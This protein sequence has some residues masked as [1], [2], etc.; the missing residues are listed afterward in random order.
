[1]ELSVS[2]LTNLDGVGLRVLEQVQVALVLMLGRVRKL[3][4][5]LVLDAESGAGTGVGF[6]FRIGFEC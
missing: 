2:K 6:G 4:V 1:M 3:F 5:G